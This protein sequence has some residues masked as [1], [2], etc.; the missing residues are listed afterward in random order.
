MAT[1]EALHTKHH[2]GATKE[3]SMKLREWFGMNKRPEAKA[4]RAAG[5]MLSLTSPGVARW[6]PRRYDRLAEAG[7]RKNVIAY[8]CIREVAQS[9]ASIP[10]LL[11]DAEG[12]ELTDH[13]LLVLLAT[14]NPMQGTA[15]LLE[16]LYAH[17]QISGNAYLE[18]VCTE[19]DDAPHELWVLRPDRV[20]IIPGPAGVPSAYEYSAGGK[21]VRWNADTLTGQADVL[22][23]KSFHPLDDWYGQSPLE[24]ASMA[25]DQH[26]AAS[27]WNQSLLQNAA[28]PSG[29]LVYAP[30]E[31]PASLTDDQYTRLK[32]ELT[33]QIEG[34]TN[35]G[36]PLL[37]EGGLE[38][39]AMSLSPSDMDWQA[40]RNAVA[41]EIALAFGVPPQLIGLPDA[42]TYSNYK[43]ARL[44]FYE[45]TVLP[46]VG[47]LR[48]ALNVWLSPMFGDD[49]RLD[50]N[51][52]AIPALAP[53]REAL[54]AKIATADFLTNDEKREAL[55]YGKY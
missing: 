11:Y 14:P 22:H 45:D 12:Q 48:D 41:R 52:D 2:I 27:A 13:P 47:H 51:L 15:Q 43:E 42:Q 19:G 8:R 38:W 26:N 40:G 5:P 24:A 36:R 31:G 23:V 49:L 1:K 9:A 44:A 29:A 34:A 21:T 7:Y 17:L 6:T 4:S 37:L 10:W 20:K 46:L 54:W 39:K 35:A 25:I 55:G 53:R 32:T 50:I 16:A 28:R 30:K 3:M 18:C 33:E